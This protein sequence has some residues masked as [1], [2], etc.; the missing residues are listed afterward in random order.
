MKTLSLDKIYTA[1]KLNFQKERYSEAEKE[2]EKI[3]GEKPLFAF[4]A[5]GRTEVGGNHTD[6]NFGKVLAGAVNIDVIAVVCK[7]D[8]DRVRIKSEG[9]AP[10]EIKLSELS[11]VESEKGSS[12]SILRGMVSRIKDLGYEVGSFDAYT[13]S[14]GPAGSGLSSSAAFRHLQP[15]LLVLL[16]F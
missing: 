10:H 4:S 9:H 5:P 14:E 8:S 1:D 11:P 15:R 12:N 13:T 7:T 3:Y 6:H 16:L 2:F